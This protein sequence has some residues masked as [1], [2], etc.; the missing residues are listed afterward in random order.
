MTL[1]FIWV[2]ARLNG[3]SAEVA[4]LASLKE[5]HQRQDVILGKLADARVE[6]SG[7]LKQQVKATETQTELLRDRLPKG[8]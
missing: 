6:H 8:G 3:G 2:K 7:L 4:T 5:D 1:G